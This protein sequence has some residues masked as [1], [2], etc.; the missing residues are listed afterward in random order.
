MGACTISGCTRAVLHRSGV[1]PISCCRGCWLSNGRRHDEECEE[2]SRAR[3]TVH[4]GDSPPW[5]LAPWCEEAGE[6]RPAAGEGPRRELQGRSAREPGASVPGAT[7]GE[8]GQETG[9]QTIPVEMLED[10]R[11]GVCV[12][13]G[14]GRVVVHRGAERPLFMAQHACCLLCWHTG[15][16]DHGP[17]CAE[18]VFFRALV[19]RPGGVGAAGPE[20]RAGALGVAGKGSGRGGEFAEGGQEC[21]SQTPAQ[22]V[23]EAGPG[24]AGTAGPATPVPGAGAVAAGPRGSRR[25]PPPPPPRMASPIPRQLPVLQGPAAVATPEGEAR[26]S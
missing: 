17:R 9:V 3:Q 25:R 11:V 20:R 23:G 2:R 24:R 10:V 14:C 19:A 7:A 16:G 15:G 12:V 5:H 6:G 8:M 21:L 1:L 18:Y 13:P 4:V 26:V 22:P